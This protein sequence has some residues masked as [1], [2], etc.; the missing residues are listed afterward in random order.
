M[1]NRSRASIPLVLLGVLAVEIVVFSVFGT[2]F[3]TRDNAA[4][5]TRLAVELGL[6][7][8]ALTPVI[9]SGGI[10]LSVG[11]L[12]GLSAVLFG[13]LWRDAALPV[14]AAAAVTLFIGLTAGAVNG[15]LVTRFRL[16][17]L[18]VTL[19]TMSLFS[20]LALGLSEGVETYTG[21]PEPFLLLGQGYSAG[22]P[23]QLPMLVLAVSGFGLLLHATTFGRAV[24]AIGFSPGAARHAGIPVE[25]R[26][27]TL[28]VLSGVAASLAGLI[29]TARLGQAKADAGTGY[30]L[31]AITAVVLGGTSIFG[32]RGT[33]HGTVLGLAV[34]VV[35]KTGLRLADVPTEWAGVLTGVL[36]LV[37][38]A[39][40][41]ARSRPPAAASSARAEG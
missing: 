12:M 29:L 6:V 10:D 7:A 40:D 5:I 27:L 38:I 31:D 26:L 23:V 15:F 41:R 37:T 8:V 28:Y 18:I 2:N 35:L 19:G 13:M 39:A 20:G 21:F 11:S 1:I 22:I 32:G 4:S 16:P 17:P 33:V 30:E 3:A 24:F 14:A 36:L 34:L 25:R 9:V